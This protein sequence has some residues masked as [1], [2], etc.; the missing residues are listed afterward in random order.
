MLPVFLR[1][2]ALAQGDDDTATIRCDEAVS[3][4]SQL[5]HPLST[6]LSYWGRGYLDQLKEDP[7][8]TLSWAERGQDLCEEYVLPLLQSH[9][10]VQIG[11]AMTRSGELADGI[12]RMR[13]G[14]A[15]IKT[16][17]AGMGLP[18]LLSLQ[19]E[20]F[21]KAGSVPSALETIEEAL[22]TSAHRGAWF[23]H[24]EVLRIKAGLIL[25]AGRSRQSEVEQVLRR[26]L[27][28]AV[29][30][31]SPRLEARATRDLALVLEDRKRGQE[32]RDLM[33][34]PEPASGGSSP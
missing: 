17:G 13:R 30:Q 15:T 9:F 29:S 11:W 7:A 3:L 31:Q 23:Q 12:D 25:K 27:E 21:G 20:A 6:A 5:S 28:T 14:T 26:A 8:G 19:A 18:Y 34:R 33:M 16:T 1:A 10:D 22:A 2:G 32:A 24:S 4:A